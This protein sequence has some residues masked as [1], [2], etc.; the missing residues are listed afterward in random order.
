[1]FGG[2]PGVI[3]GA[4]AGAGTGGV[5]AHLIDLGF[6]KESLRELQDSLQ[7]G[8]SAIVLLIEPTWI[9]RVVKEMKDFGGQLFRHTLETARVQL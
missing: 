3:V 7:P 9:D 6:P 2:V 4:A 1:M 8:S 5:A